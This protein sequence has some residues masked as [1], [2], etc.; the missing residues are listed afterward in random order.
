MIGLGN[1]VSAAASAPGSGKILFDL[2]GTGGNIWGNVIMWIAFFVLMMFYP[3]LII[4]QMLW[5]L[6]MAAATI[7]DRTKK[8]KKIVI[9]SISKKPSRKLRES[10]GNFMEFFM[11]QPVSLD[12]YG[13]IKKLEH[14]MNM[15]EE[16]FKYFVDQVAPKMDEESKQ[17]LRMGLSGA[18]SLNQIAK[19]VRHFVETVR[20]TKNLQLA[21]VLQM[22]LPMI[23][24]LSKAL[25]SGTEALTS[26]WVISDGIGSM[27]AAHMA[28]TSRMKKV[29]EGTMLVTKRMAGRKVFIM[30]AQGPGGRLGKIGRA[31]ERIIKRN[32]IAKI[33]TVDAAAKLEGERTGK[34]AEGVG[35]AI[36][37][38]GVDRSYIENI[39]VKKKIPL[40]SIVIK[41]SQEEAIQPIKKE[42]FASIPRVLQVV[43]ERIKSTR[44]RGAVL[45]V[46]VG[47]SSGIGDNKREAQKSE[48]QAKKI[49]KMLKKRD[50]KLEKKKKDRWKNLFWTG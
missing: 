12:P 7:E 1:V 50:K 31:A 49:L 10:V 16:R 26:G 20:K 42:V 4:A 25:L 32:K 5:K 35:V 23:E 21:M 9:R 14:T 39:A 44:G 22:Q 6:E 11:I 36:G 47:N 2:F 41:M 28:G 17:N 15:S 30:K 45:V 18:V 27:V 48:V 24:R 34:I 43:D 8:G 38:M 3:R 19:V 37:G 46:G 13:I 33:I 29:D 40:D